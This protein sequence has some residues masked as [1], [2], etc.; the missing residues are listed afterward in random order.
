MGK[1]INELASQQNVQ[2]VGHSGG[3]HDFVKAEGY[4]KADGIIEF[5]N[6]ASAFSNISQC[7][8]DGLPVVCGTTGWLDRWDD[9][10]A[11][12]KEQN[13]KL[14][15]ASNFSFGANVMFYL[16]QKLAGL[17][18][19]HTEY[20]VQIEEIH[21]MEK[22]DKPSGTAKTLADDI[23]K[24]NTQK[25]KWS[26]QEADDESTL[27]INCRRE[28]N[29]KGI[30]QIDYTS[31]I[32]RISIKHDAFSRDGFAL[33]ALMAFNWLLDKPSGVYG[34]KDMLGLK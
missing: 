19:N 4:G 9:I 32:D 18:A 29:V 33:G 20:D 25:Q 23:I 3:S 15:Y 27:F 21:H 22:L 34:M 7:L 10:Q 28:P 13:G 26:I 1:K 2:V 12:C 17:M 11:I 8:K 30:H 31:P 14:F 24:L 6:P 16:N 5:T